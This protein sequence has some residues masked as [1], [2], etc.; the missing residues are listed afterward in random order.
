MII[1]DAHTVIQQQ[2]LEITLSWYSQSVSPDIIRCWCL[3]IAKEHGNTAFGAVAD[4][5]VEVSGM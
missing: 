5:M 2:I 3:I 4:R 1:E